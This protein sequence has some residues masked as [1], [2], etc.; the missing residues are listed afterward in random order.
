ML[1]PHLMRGGYRF[2]E[3]IMPKQELCEL[4]KRIHPAPKIL[5]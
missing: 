3:K 1:A 5:L 2:S 4:A